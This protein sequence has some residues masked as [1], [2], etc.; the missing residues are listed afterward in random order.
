MSTV[1]SLIWFVSLIAFIVFWRKKKVARKNAGENYQTD[2]VYTKI[3]KQKRI[4]G[5]ICI[6]SLLIAG[7]TAPESASDTQTKSGVS[8]QEQK[9]QQR[10]YE[11]IDIDTMMAD[12]EKNAASASKKYKGKYLKI[13][14]GIVSNID[15]DGKYFNVETGKKFEL[16]GVQCFTQNKEQKDQLS[17]LQKKGPVTVYGRISDVG[18]ILGYSLQIDKFEVQ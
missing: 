7:G 10:Q 8:T 6:V 5:I 11:T 15:A 17:Q 9:K 16:K 13:T 14:N 12:L 18:E 1:F 2:P 4:I 3:S